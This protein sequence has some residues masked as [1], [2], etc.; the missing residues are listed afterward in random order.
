[1][2][3][4]LSLLYLILNIHRYIHVYIILADDYSSQSRSAHGICHRIYRYFQAFLGIDNVVLC[5]IHQIQ[6]NTSKISL[7]VVILIIQHIDTPVKFKKIIKKAC[8]L[9]T[10]AG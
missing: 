10:N 4:L 3:I 1:M 8:L 6:N 7:F 2:Q 9:L 5:L